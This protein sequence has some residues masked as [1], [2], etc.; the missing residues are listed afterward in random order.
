M[1]CDL[2]VI[3]RQF[4]N[5]KVYETIFV[6][7]TLAKTLTFIIV[8]MIKLVVVKELVESIQS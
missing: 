2:I 8:N 1:I 7:Q 5:E 3:Y 6:L 4:Q